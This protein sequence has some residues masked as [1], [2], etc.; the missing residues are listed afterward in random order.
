MGL[1]TA[2]MMSLEMGTKQVGY[3]LNASWSVSDD[4]TKL[5]PIGQRWPAEAVFLGSDVT[6]FR[7]SWAVITDADLVSKGLIPGGNASVAT[8][9][10]FPQMTAIVRDQV[11]GKIQNQLEGVFVTMNNFNV[12]GRSMVSRDTQLMALKHVYGS[13]LGA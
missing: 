4:R 9:V 3:L 8:C 6:D 1:F 11:G 12:S 5:Y 7:A 13:E 10:N 2:A